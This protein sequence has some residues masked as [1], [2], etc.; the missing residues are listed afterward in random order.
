MVPGWALALQEQQEAHL[1][2]GGALVSR[3][4]VAGQVDAQSAEGGT[5]VTTPTPSW[6]AGTNIGRLCTQTGAPTGAAC[7]FALLMSVTSRCALRL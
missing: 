3:A 2:G 4:Q 6:P 7:S 1:D 5:V